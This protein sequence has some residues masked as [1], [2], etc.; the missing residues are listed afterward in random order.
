MAMPVAHPGPIMVDASALAADA[1]TV[2]TLARLQLAARRLG[3][4][5]QLREVSDDLQKLIAFVGLAVVLGIEPCRQPEE[6]EECLGAE[7]ERELGDPA[8]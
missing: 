6:R 8:T 3:C 7:E 4:R 5:V 1:V 2:D